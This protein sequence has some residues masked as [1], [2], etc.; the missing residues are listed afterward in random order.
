MRIALRLTPQKS[1]HGLRTANAI[2][3]GVGSPQFQTNTTA[4][5]DRHIGRVRLA[6]MTHRIMR[7]ITSRNSIPSISP[8]LTACALGIRPGM[9]LAEVMSMSKHVLQDAATQLRKAAWQLD[10]VE[11][12]IVHDVTNP[13]SIKHGLSVA[14]ANI[15]AALA[16][17]E[18]FRQ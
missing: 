8:R 10:A 13:G 9:P 1:K 4:M 6:R 3:R 15:N 5:P 11:S 12:D 7:C 18:A 2:G 17:I 16:R 14:E